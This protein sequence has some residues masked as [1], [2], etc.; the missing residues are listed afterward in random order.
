METPAVTEES[1]VEE[2]EVKEDPAAETST[3]TVVVDE[4]NMVDGVDCT[5]YNQSQ[6]TLMDLFAF[7]NEVE[8]DELRV[9]VKGNNGIEAV[10]SDGDTFVMNEGNEYSFVYYAP[11][12]VKSAERVVEGFFPDYDNIYMLYPNGHGVIHDYSDYTKLQKDESK[13]VEV[14]VVY[15]DGTEGSITITLTKNY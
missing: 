9:F 8:C 4:A 10:L 2:S 5:A 11:K 12:K 1:K 3:E 6:G 7:V 13:S 15:D 14:D